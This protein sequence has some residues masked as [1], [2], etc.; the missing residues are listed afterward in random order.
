MDGMAGVTMRVGKVNRACKLLAFQPIWWRSRR[1]LMLCGLTKWCVRGSEVGP[2]GKEIIADEKPDQRQTNGQNLE[3]M[4]E[5]GLHGALKRSRRI[6]HMTRYCKDRRPLGGKRRDRRE[7]RKEKDKKMQ[8]LGGPFA[9][10]SHFI[11]T[12]ASSTPRPSCVPI[13][14]PRPC[15]LSK[16]WST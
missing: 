3:T 13:H 9:Q 12:P 5:R 15:S 16:R 11:S 4:G 14:T 6:Q 2:S 7:K 1:E 10:R 8:Q